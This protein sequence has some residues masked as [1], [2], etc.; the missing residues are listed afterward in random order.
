VI[1]VSLPSE[2]VPYLGPRGLLDLDCASGD[3]SRTRLPDEVFDDAIGGVAL[4][5]RLYADAP[6]GDPL[7]F[8]AGPFGS[9]PVPAGYAHAYAFRRPEGRLAA[10]LAPSHWSATLR[11]CG[12]AAVVLRGRSPYPALIV[13]DHDRVTVEDGRWLPMEDAKATV[14]AVRKRLVDRTARVVTMTEGGTLDAAMA[15]KGIVAVAVRGR[16][17]VPVA[18][19]AA[20]AQAMEGL[21]RRLATAPATP[22]RPRERADVVELRAGCAGCPVQCDQMYVVR[23]RPGRHPRPA[24][25]A[26]PERA[27]AAAELLWESLV[28]CRF[29]RHVIDDLPAEGAALLRA[30]NGGSA[31]AASVAAAADRALARWHALDVAND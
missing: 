8:T 20:A 23:E 2:T 10:G 27:P 19:P 29:V 11:R 13:V 1:P 31:D 5:L 25:D 12:L 6:H 3:A 16:G 18:D 30:V 9:T 17:E 22:E 15:A 21:R 14:K 24:V 26:P 4:A 7:I 28:L